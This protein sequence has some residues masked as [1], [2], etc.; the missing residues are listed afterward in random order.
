MKLNFLWG[1]F[2]FVWLQTNHKQIFFNF[3][4]EFD[5]TLRIFPF[6]LAFVQRFGN[7]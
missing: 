7:F 2:F 1:K 6:S 4:H 3:G 5:L